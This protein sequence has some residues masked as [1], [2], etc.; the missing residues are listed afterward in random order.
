MF[1]KIA[2]EISA[3]TRLGGPNP[4]DNP[5]LRT[6]LAKAKAANMPKDNWMRAIKKGS[7]EG[8][9]AAYE[10]KVYEGYGSGGIALIVECLTDNLNRTI[11][12]IRFAFT[13]AGGGVGSE[14]S[15][16]WMFQRKGL[17]VISRSNITDIEQLFEL[18]LE[19]GAE[20]IEE[21]DDQVEISC[22][23][24]NFIGLKEKIEALPVTMDFCELTRI[25]DN[26]VAI[27]EEQQ[28]SLQK[29]LDALEDDEDVQNVF[30]NAEMPDN[31]E[32]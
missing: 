5:R 2:V 6:A 21:L 15:V 26:T 25:A 9:G 8:G 24:E 12:N 30:H 17:I 32:E 4:E 10:E 14:G 7:G 20:D 1:T 23:T 28:V 31:D 16:S 19:N 11:S 22:S 27:S 18:A 3:A 29:L 13:R